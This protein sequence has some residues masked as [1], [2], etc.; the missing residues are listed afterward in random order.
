MVTSIYKNHL[1]NIAQWDSYVMQHKDALPYHLSGFALTTQS[2]SNI[3]N[4]YLLSYQ[5]NENKANINGLLIVSQFKGLN[6]KSSLCSLPYCDVSYCLADNQQVE[7]ELLKQAQSLQSKLKISKWIYRDSETEI[8][9]G[10]LSEHD[11]IR[12]LLPLPKDTDTLW[13]Q[14]KAKLRNQIRKAEKCDLSYEINSASA[15][16]DF[17]EVYSKNMHALGSPPHPKA[18]FASL[19]TNYGQKMQVVVI[20]KGSVNVAAGVLLLTDKIACVPWASSLREYNK[21]NSNMLLYWQMLSLAI[22][23]GCQT[24]DFGRSSYGEN[25]YRFKKQWG[26]Q[27][28]RLQWQEFSLSGS[29]MITHSNSTNWKRAALAKIWSKLPLTLSTLLGGKIRKYISL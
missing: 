29:S 1:V 18:W 28:L 21:L 27:P 7:D 3:N 24:F 17:Y 20:K 10:Q 13:Q 5:G 11:K 14:L 15:I 6:G 16:A 12:M 19:Q 8:Y 9:Q 25:T 26:A 2:C 4:Y 23:Q 22:A